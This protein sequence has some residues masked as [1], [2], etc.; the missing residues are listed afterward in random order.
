MPFLR[1]KDALILL[2]TA[3]FIPV[4]LFPGLFAA[5]VSAA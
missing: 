2:R 3:G 5:G 1:G 4:F